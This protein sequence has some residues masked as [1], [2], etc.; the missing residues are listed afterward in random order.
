MDDPV[1]LEAEFNPKVKIYWLLTGCWI[2]LATIVGIVLIP[3]WVILGPLVIDRYVKRLRCALTERSAILNKGLL[4]R[5]EKTVPL[6]KITDVGLVQGPIM[7]MLDLQALSFET[8]GQTSNLA[9]TLSVVGIQDGR[10]FRDAVLKQ[11]DQVTLG[12]SRDA[13]ATTPPPAS[14]GGAAPLSTQTLQEMLAVL[15]RIEQ[16]LDR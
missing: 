8:A 6:D 4:I 14:N 7:R 16:K 15:K 11:R 3:I 10:D 2:L 9:A 13:T 5:V 1:L 12:S